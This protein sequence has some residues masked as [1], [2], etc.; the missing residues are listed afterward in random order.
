MNTHDTW[1]DATVLAVRDLTP[2]VREFQ[3][4]YPQAV[5]ADPGAHI[6]VQV[7]ANGQPDSRSY[8]VVR[9]EGA[10]ATI[11]VKHVPSSRGGS[12]YMW[13]LAQGARLK[14]TAPA[15]DLAPVYGSA[16]YLLIAGGIGITPLLSVA[17]ALAGSGADVRMAYAVRT[18]AELAYLAE[19]Q[20][21]LGNRLR[22]FVSARNQ[23]ID[24][25][26][27]IAALA[28]TDQL[29]LCGP[30]GLMEAVRTHWFAAGRASSRLRYETFGSSGRYPAADFTVRLPR[31]G[32]EIQVPAEQSML[33]ALTEAGV[34]MVSNC[35][36][37]ECGLCAVDVLATDGTADHR[38][39]FFTREQHAQGGK[40]CTCVSRMAQGS[41]TIEP[42]WRGDPDLAQTDVLAS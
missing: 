8:S 1:L 18:E 5:H 16:R 26:G 35:R 34:A 38:D 17:R 22:V 36:R 24:I 4:Q 6:D 41:I 27:E 14:A 2:T 31:L 42:P 12:R 7:M 20:E 32:L 9:C 29:Y 15:S 39:V 3:L 13:S 37:G 23:R 10:N 33:D 40:I 11:A 28:D 30:M 19:L 25:P 21:L